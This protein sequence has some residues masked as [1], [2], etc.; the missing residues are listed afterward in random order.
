M[1]RKFLSIVYH[2]ILPKR[3]LSHIPV[4]VEKVVKYLSSSN[5]I[6]D[7]TFGE[8]GHT[9]ALLESSPKSSIICVDRDPNAFKTAE[10]LSQQYPNRIYP[11]HGKFSDLPVI[12]KKLDVNEVDGILFDFGCSSGQLDIA[13]RGFALSKTGP[14]DMR[15]DPQ[16]DSLTAADIIQYAEEYDLYRIFK[17]YGGE[18]KARTIA[19]AIVENRYTFSPVKTTSDLAAL[20]AGIIP[21]RTDKLGRSAHPATKIFQALRIFV[22]DELNE[23]DYA[24]SLS[25]YFLKLGGTLVTISFHS[26]EDTIVKRHLTGNLLENS[27]NPLPLKYSSHF[28]CN[29]DELK[30]DSNWVMLTKHVETPTDEELASN[31]R[32][33]SAKLRAAI[34]VN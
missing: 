21:S 2:Q 30:K 23:I 29:Q 9:K 7:M 28:L 15:M 24:M 14:L 31:P 33:R 32:S 16:S 34:K 26:L 11:F 3:N 5:L 20:V 27:A 12:L 18:K 13:D 1:R 6:I 25:R 8:G 10:L 19:R 4:M 22:N 17:I